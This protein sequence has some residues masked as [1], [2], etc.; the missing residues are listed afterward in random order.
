MR[1]LTLLAGLMLALALGACSS[2]TSQKPPAAAAPAP[3]SLDVVLSSD[4]SAIRT[5]AVE[6]RPIADV[7]QVPARIQPDPARVIRVFAPV[8]GRLLSLDV[9]PGD[10]VAKGQPLALLDSS[11]V[12]SARADYQKAR[13]D[14]E[15]KERALR[16][17]SML[18]ENKVLSEKDFQQAQADAASSEAELHRTLDR[19]RVLGVDAEGSSSQFKVLAPRAGVV[20]DI[21]AAAGEFSKS[22][23]APQALCTLADLSSIWVVGDLLERDVAGLKRGL[24]AEVRVTA[25]PSEKWTG[26]ITTISDVLDPLTHTVKLRVVLPNSAGRLKPEMFAV[27]RL[28]RASL[29][30]LIL[31]AAAVVREAEKSFVYVQKSA[32]H[33]ERREVSLGRTTDGE[34]EI[35]SGLKAGE[36]VVAEGAL[37]LRAAAS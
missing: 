28:P 5:V 7:L 14:A 33:F 31:P 1:I 21:G 35:T 12:S 4:S 6:V 27:I 3:S 11:E 17:A 22:L 24:S 32:G 29:P 18:Y 23:D 30:G 13:A 2:S 8:G 26:R 36:Q 19:L 9:R 16:R 25:Y 15:L 37:L 34:V 10:H 20:L